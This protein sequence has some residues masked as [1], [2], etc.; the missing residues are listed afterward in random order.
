M[1]AAMAAEVQKHGVNDCKC[2]ELRWVS[3]PLAVETYGCWGAEAQS[4]ISRLASCLAIQLQCSKSKAITTIYQLLN[5][6]L[7]RANARALLSHSGFFRS[8]GGVYLFLHA[9]Q[10]V[11][12]CTSTCMSLSIYMFLY[13]YI[14]WNSGSI[15]GPGAFFSGFQLLLFYFLRDTYVLYKY[16]LMQ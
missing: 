5:L 11:Y 13:I 14:I 7:V 10:V 15:M 9:F 2:A 4:T 1:S 6:T 12:M 16:F 8:E 3:I